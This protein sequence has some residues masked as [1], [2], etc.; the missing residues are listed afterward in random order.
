M[1]AENEPGIMQFAKTY[2][3]DGLNKKYDKHKRVGGTAN[4]IEGSESGNFRKAEREHGS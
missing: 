1:Q 4:A 2:N 3:S